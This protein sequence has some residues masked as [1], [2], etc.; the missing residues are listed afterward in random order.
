MVGLVVVSHSRALAEALVELV[1]QA[2]GTDLPVAAAGGVGDERRQPGTD[3]TD[4]AAAIRSVYTGKGVVVL[5]DMG[6]AVLSAETAL[7]V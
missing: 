2:A 1:G 3:A 7:P 6:S 5:M 4:V